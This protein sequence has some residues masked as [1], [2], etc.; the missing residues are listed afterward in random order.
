MKIIEKLKVKNADIFGEK[1]VTIAFLGDSVTQGCFE[2][3][4]DENGVI[5]TVFDAKSAYP[6]RVKEILGLLYPKA[7]LN[8]INSGISG[9]NAVIGNGRFERD[10][11]PF[12]PDL[13]VVSFGL[14]DSCGGADNLKNYTDALESI[15]GKVS[16]IGAECVFVFQNTMNVKVSPHLK[17]ERE[18]KLAKDFAKIQN[19]GGLRAYR[20]AARRAADKHGVAFID[21]YSAWEKMND[22]GVDTTDLLANY[23]NH[24]K[25]EFHYY[26][27]IKIVEKLFE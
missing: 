7:Q 22:S 3:Y 1:P 6:T 20:D 23:Y 14:N 27:A 8:L 10:V 24:P 9:D 12:S 13:V 16:S 26:T 25:R 19:E 15:F 17:E 11:A 2:C 21:I 18:Q 5:Q 4:F